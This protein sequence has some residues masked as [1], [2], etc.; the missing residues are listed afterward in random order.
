MIDFHKVEAGIIPG[1][2]SAYDMEC[3]Y[4]ALKDSK[5][6][7]VYLEIGVDRG[8]SLTFARKFFKGDVFGIDIETIKNRS[9]KGLIPGTNF[10]L[11]DS[12][13]VKWTLPIKVLFIDGEHR[14]QRVRD[15][16]AK[17]SPLVVKGGWV[18][19]HDCDDTSPEVVRA[20]SKIDGKLWKKG[21]SKNQRCSMAWAQKL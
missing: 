13:E 1:W 14:Y 3:I 6:D 8:R 17:Y 16:W 18:F 10:I 7:D 9:G 2:F 15:E 5:K 11:G 20:F 21:K 19:F 4:P 12:L